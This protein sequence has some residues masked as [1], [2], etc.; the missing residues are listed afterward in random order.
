MFS[1]LEE[2]NLALRNDNPTKTWK[3]VGEN[4]PLRSKLTRYFNRFF[5][6]S[7]YIQINTDDCRPKQSIKNNIF[8]MTKKNKSETQLKKA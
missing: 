3:F 4:E 2:F 6:F 8:A 7:K 1:K 5:L